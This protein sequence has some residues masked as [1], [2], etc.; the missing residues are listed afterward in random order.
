MPSET[1][2]KEAKVAEGV[3]EYEVVEC[4]ACGNHVLPENAESVE[5]GGEYVGEFCEMCDNK[6]NIDIIGGKK[7]SSRLGDFLY[8][9][10]FFC[11]GF[12]IFIVGL[13]YA[14]KDM[15]NINEEI[16]PPLKDYSIILIISTLVWM[17]LMI[18][19][20]QIIF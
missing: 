10:G 17:A 20:W 7:D 19:A 16:M 9:L 8:S 5:I 15:S 4:A 13:I 1:K 11:A 3:V 14:D 6:Q 12:P 18:L 2:V